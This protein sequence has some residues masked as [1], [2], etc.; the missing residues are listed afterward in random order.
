MTGVQTCALPIYHNINFGQYI[1]ELIRFNYEIQD[2]FIISFSIIWLPNKGN[3]FKNLGDVWYMQL[4]TE[5]SY[6]KTYVKIRAG[7]KV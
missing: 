3:N 6:L 7:E 2:T 1:I 4:K 5:N